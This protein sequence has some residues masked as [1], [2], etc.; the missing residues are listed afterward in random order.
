MSFIHKFE[1]LS[2]RQKQIDEL[3]G[4]R[5]ASEK[6]I[7]LDEATNEF[8]LAKEI[9]IESKYLIF[10][11]DNTRIRTSVLN[12]LGNVIL[13]KEEIDPLDEFYQKKEDISTQNFLLNLLLERAK[14]VAS[15]YKQLE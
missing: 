15:I 14:S 4:K 3:R 9:E 1:D 12:H 13:K 2:S 11:P 8:D 6:R 7:Y 10:N 5:G